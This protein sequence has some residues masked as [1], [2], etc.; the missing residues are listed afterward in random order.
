MDKNISVGHQRRHRSDNAY[1]SINFVK[2]LLEA[3]LARIN[4]LAFLRAIWQ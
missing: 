3:R 2:R 4:D 1:C